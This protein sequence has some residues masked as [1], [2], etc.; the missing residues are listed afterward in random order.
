MI[1]QKRLSGNAFR[2]VG[3]RIASASIRNI[4]KPRNA[5]IAAILIVAGG[6]IGAA[7]AGFG[8]WRVAFQGVHRDE[9]GLVE[10]VNVGEFTTKWPLEELEGET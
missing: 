6:A 10:S 5:S 1:D 4:T 7:C 2:S 9:R 3:S 8:A